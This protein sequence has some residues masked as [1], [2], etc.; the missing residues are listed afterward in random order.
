MSVII[1]VKRPEDENID[2]IAINSGSDYTSS[3]S[4]L[5]VAGSPFTVRKGPIR[6][7]EF[8]N[9]SGTLTT[10]YS[11][12]WIDESGA[13]GSWS[14][15]FQA[16]GKPYSTSQDFWNWLN[17]YNKVRN[18]SVAT[19][20]GTSTVYQLSQS[21]IIDGTLEIRY[22]TDSSVYTELL[23]STDFSVDMD[24][25]TIYIETS[26]VAKITGLNMYANYNW[27]D[28]PDSVVKD[29][30]KKADK[31]IERDCNRKFNRYTKT[32]YISVEKYDTDFMTTCYPVITLSTVEENT[33]G[34]GQSP[35]WVTRSAGLGSDYFADDDDL[36]VGIFHFLGNND[37]QDGFKNVRVTYDYGF[38][39]IPRDVQQL[40]TLISVRNAIIS[41]VFA[42]ALIKG[43]N[44]FTGLNPEALNTQ[45]TN[46][47]T[48]LQKWKIVKV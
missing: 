38:D 1:R 48:I 43:Q 27:S 45:I 23:P 9:T 31:E 36:A 13:T 18:E 32:E 16:V 24:D 11:V 28:I 17:Y 4:Y 12:A 41:P 39:E 29:F 37:P 10:W 34:R 8:E 46:N 19:S 15:P 42:Q 47:K 30:I 44:T 7:L 5:P 20:A 33:A 14:A 2:K 25:G 26:G 6:V 21:Q 3:G 40:S 35:F 22:G